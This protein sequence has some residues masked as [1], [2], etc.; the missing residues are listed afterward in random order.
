M[1]GPVRGTVEA[2]WLPDPV[3]SNDPNNYKPFDE[4]VGQ[5]TDDSARPSAQNYT[6][7]A[8]AEELQVGYSFFLFIHSLKRR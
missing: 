3:L 7:K 5:N 1:R 6:V 4:V 2:Q 8:V